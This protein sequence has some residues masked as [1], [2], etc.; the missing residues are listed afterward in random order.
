MRSI[1]NLIAEQTGISASQI[2]NTLELLNEGA[3]IPFISRYRKERTGS[4]DEVA[5]AAIKESYDRFNELEKRKATILKTI[6]EQ[7]ALTSELKERI[8]NCYDS[9][10]LE[11]IYL[12]QKPKS[13]DLN[14]LPKS[15]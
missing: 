2:Q 5:I 4:L 14:R 10:E 8:E 6:E 12:P 7:D 1:P 11:D 3:T 15:L 13:W 9:T